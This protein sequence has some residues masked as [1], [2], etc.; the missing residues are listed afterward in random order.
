[1]RTLKLIFGFGIAFSTPSCEVPEAQLETIETTETTVK[2]QVSDIE[3]NIDIENFKIE[4]ARV[5]DDTSV[6]QYAL[7]TEIID[8]VRTDANGNYSMTFDYIHGERYTFM[9][10][11]GIPYYYEPTRPIQITKGVVNVVNMDAWYPTILK[12]NLN[13]TNNEFPHLRVRNKIIGKENFHFPT[14]A[15][16]ETQI[17]TTVYLK[18]RPNSNVELMFYYST[19][20]S[21]GG[22]HRYFET[23]T[24][25]L[26]DTITLSYDIDCSSF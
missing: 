14:A 13:V 19:D 3:R 26:Q 6:V 9:H 2:G 7:G 1:M 5:W 11:Y 4:L 24:T 21:N 25:T 16:F 8:S 15:I 18:T 10:Q 17:D 23:I 22:T 20:G 12:L